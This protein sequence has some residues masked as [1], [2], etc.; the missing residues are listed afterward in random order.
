ELIAGAVAHLGLNAAPQGFGRREFPGKL[1]NGFLQQPQRTLLFPQFGIATEFGLQ[2]RCFRRAELAV[3]II[4]QE[5]FPLVCAH[6]C[7]ASRRSLRAR[8]T[9]AL[10]VPTA[11]PVILLISWCSIPSTS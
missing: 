11:M 7:S 5:G 10:D 1:R 8:C 3:D 6:D 4:V 9:W 2:S